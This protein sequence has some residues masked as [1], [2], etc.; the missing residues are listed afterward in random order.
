MSHQ[1]ARAEKTFITI[2]RSEPLVAL[3]LLFKAPTA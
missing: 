1:A 2:F 3:Q